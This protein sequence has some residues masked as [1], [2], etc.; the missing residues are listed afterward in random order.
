MSRLLRFWI[1]TLTSFAFL[2]FAIAILTSEVRFEMSSVSTTATVDS[3][4][5]CQ[6]FAKFGVTM[7]GR[8]GGTVMHLVGGQPVKATFRS[9]H[10]QRGPGK[11]ERISVLYLPAEPRFVKLDS[12]MQRYGPI[13]FPLVL[14]FAAAYWSGILR[15]RSGPAKDI[16]EHGEPPQSPISREFSS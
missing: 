13:V 16:G 15:F 11:G 8:G 2:G 9:Y 5:P 1:G 10:F 14:A 3:Y 6:L 4:T 7:I 12:L